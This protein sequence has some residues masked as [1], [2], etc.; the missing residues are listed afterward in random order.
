[1]HRQEQSHLGFGVRRQYMETFYA[2][3]AQG[4]VRA[5]GSHNLEELQREIEY[6][7][8]CSEVDGR[9]RR[10]KLIPCSKGGTSMVN[11]RCGKEVW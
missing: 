3:D 7:H 10:R 2:V 9:S 6:E 1:M 4:M 11:S 5:W 8:S